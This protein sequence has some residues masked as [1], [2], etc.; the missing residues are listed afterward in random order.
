[1]GGVSTRY[2]PYRPPVSFSRVQLHLGSAAQWRCW[3]RLLFWIACLAHPRP[4]AWLIPSGS[5]CWSPATGLLCLFVQ[6]VRSL[7]GPCKG[8]A[9]SA[10]PPH[11]R[12]LLGGDDSGSGPTVSILGLLRTAWTA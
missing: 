1:M 9:R 2:Q 6:G 8:C 11:D 3:G 4:T 10:T 12:R 5:G 7:G